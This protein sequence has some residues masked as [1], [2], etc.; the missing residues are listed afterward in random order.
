MFWN[1]DSRCHP[2]SHGHPLHHHRHPPPLPRQNKITIGPFP[3]LRFLIAGPARLSSDVH[4]QEKQ[5][6]TWSASI[7]AGRGLRASSERRW[8]GRT[9]TEWTPASLTR[10]A[11][12]R[13]NLKMESFYAAISP[14][15][16]STGSPAGD[17]VQMKTY[18]ECICWMLWWVITIKCHSSHLHALT[19]GCYGDLPCSA[20]C[21]WH[22]SCNSFKHLPD[23][24]GCFY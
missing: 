18:N 4:L 22:V 13:Q 21:S 15:L 3:R 12:K 7:N 17:V 8:A 24:P 14:P 6:T 23:N 11:I 16:P 1:H 10:A 2:G 9:G 19:V 20:L 5:M